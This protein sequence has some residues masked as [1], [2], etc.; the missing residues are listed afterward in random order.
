[1]CKLTHQQPVVLVGFDRIHEVVEQIVLDLGN[2]LLESEQF[3]SEITA[4]HHRCFLV[5]RQVHTY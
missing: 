4:A 2:F 5:P 1:M 3:W